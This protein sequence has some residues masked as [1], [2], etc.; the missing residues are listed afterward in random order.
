MGRL[1]D[2]VHI[3]SAWLFD[4]NK[5]LYWQQFIKLLNNHLRDITNVE[6]FYFNILE[7]ASRYASKQDIKRVLVE[8]YIRLL[9]YEGRLHNKFLCFI[10]EKYIN[11]NLSISR[12]FLPSHYN[13]SY[14]TQF[15]KQKIENLFKTKDTFL[16]N[17]DDIHNCWHILSRGI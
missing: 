2:I 3:S 10:C 6:Q 11:N 9:E 7:E 5:T 1:K 12:A 4:L 15:D 14:D 16:L 17:D 13:C 8:S